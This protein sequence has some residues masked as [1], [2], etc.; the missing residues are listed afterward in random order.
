MAVG[1]GERDLG[2]ISEVCAWQ[3]MSKYVDLVI[4]ATYG[5]DSMLRKL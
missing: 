5:F 2:D 4:V 3:D 1:I